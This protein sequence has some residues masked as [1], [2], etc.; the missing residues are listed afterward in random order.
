MSVAASKAV[1]ETVE[2]LVLEDVDELR[3]A[4]VDESWGNAE[5]DFWH[6]AVPEVALFASHQVPMVGTCVVEAGQPVEIKSARATI[7]DGT[8]TRFGRFNLTRRQHERLLEEGGVYLFAIYAGAAGQE[9]IRGLLAMPAFI[10]EDD[11]R[12][13]WYDVDGREDY[14]QLA[15]SRIPID[16]LGGESA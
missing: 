5:A 7:S 14:W 3:E 16:G 10:V 15:A 1:G 11:L 12:S 4:D 13:T 2:D 9:E 6:D 8:G